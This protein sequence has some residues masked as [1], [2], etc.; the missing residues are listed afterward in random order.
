MG[1]TNTSM[2]RMLATFGRITW[3]GALSRPRMALADDHFAAKMT[4]TMQHQEAD[5]LQ[6]EADGIYLSDGRE[7]EHRLM[8]KK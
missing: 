8:Y 1:Y 4:G 7:P 2:H 6:R 5:I 3:E